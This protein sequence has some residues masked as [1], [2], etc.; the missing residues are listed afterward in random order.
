M[1]LVPKEA[2]PGSGLYCFR[3]QQRACTAECMAY[4]NPPE[5]D[6]YKG[7]Q[8]A[9]CLELISLHRSG[10]HLALLAVYGQKLLQLHHNG[11]AERQRTNQ[12]PP[13]VPK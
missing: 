1:P 6:E 12:Q 13:P 8:W 9:H 10:K 2:V 4:V 3:D 7:Q 5:G 11:A